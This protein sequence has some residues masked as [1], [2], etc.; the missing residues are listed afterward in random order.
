MDKHVSSVPI[1]LPTFR[2]GCI[3][4]LD[5]SSQIQVSVIIA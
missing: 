4:I 3:K 1:S 5:R 2:K